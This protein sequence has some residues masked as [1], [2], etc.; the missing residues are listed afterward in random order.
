MTTHVVIVDKDTFQQHLKYKFIGTGN[1]KPFLFNNVNTSNDIHSSTE[2]NQFAMLADCNRM[3]IGDYV[4]FYLQQSS[5]I[6]GF[7]GLFKVSS[8][9]FIHKEQEEN[10]YPDLTKN[11]EYRAFIEPFKVYESPVSEW[12]AL[13]DIQ[14]LTSPCQMLWSLIY[15]KLKGNRGNTMI[16]LYESERL[17][18]LIMLKNNRNCL[19]LQK[20]ESLKYNQETNKLEIVQEQ[21]EVYRKERE[22]IDIKNRII[23]KDSQNQ[24]YET[25]L[26]AYI[27]QNIGTNSVSSLDEALFSENEHVIWIGNEVSC[28]VGMQR[29]DIVVVTEKDGQELDNIYVIELKCT[30]LNTDNI[31]QMYRYID[32]ISQYYL[33]NK[34]SIVC[35]ILLTKKDDNENN[36]SQDINKEIEHFSTKFNGLVNMC[37]LKLVFYEI[38]NDDILFS[39]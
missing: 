6:G 11:L 39:L 34:Q 8:L 22:C 18:S 28:G 3:R 21:F 10:D 4:I 2:K 25:H 20:N 5:N 35:P 16:T 26:Q 15:R 36:I 14:R 24:K 12:E 33:P 37:P 38:N 17:I 7:F 31:K 1:G 27:I 32:W 30:P 13:D 19:N 29:M 9:P 23:F